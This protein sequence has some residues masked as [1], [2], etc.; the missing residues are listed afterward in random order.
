M[1]YM[2]RLLN[3]QVQCDP[4]RHWLLMLAL[5]LPACSQ[6]QFLAKPIPQQ[7]NQ[8]SIHTADPTQE[9]FKQYLAVQSPETQWPIAQW[10]LNALTLSAWYF[11]PTLKVAKS[12]YA[13]ALA[14]ITAAGLRP[15]IGLNGLIGKSNQANGDIRPFLY[16]L[17]FDIPIVTNGKREINIEIARHQADVAKIQLGEKAWQLRYQLSA[18]ILDRAE[19]MTTQSNLKQLQQAQFDLL[20]AF[21]KR[22]QTGMIGKAELLP[23]QLQYEQSKWQFA[24]NQI[25]LKQLEQKIVHDAGLTEQHLNTTSFASL[26]LSQLL[27]RVIESA[28]HGASAPLANALNIQ[29]V[30]M[31]NRMDIQRGLAQ[32]AQAEAKLKLEIAKLRPDISLS[33]GVAY[34]FGDQVWSLGIGGLLNLLNRSSDL[35]KQAEA[36]RQNEAD[37]FYALQHQIVQQ[38]EQQHLNFIQSY[39]LLEQLEQEAQQQPQRLNTIEQQ[40]KKGLI[41]KTEWLQS[42]VQ[43][44]HLNQRLISQ[45]ATVLRALLE[46]ENTMQMPL[47][48][49]ATSFTGNPQ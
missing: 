21:E 39:Q 42:Q 8:V 40:W 43:F 41:D 26:D 20:H 29:A 3:N 35:W 11:H 10:D 45:R 49:A 23:I 32:Y 36:V 14:G 13:V 33:P 19:L 44:Y 22:L 5:T 17:Q 34:E 1:P 16:N 25:Q 15:Q 7:E 9:G 6:V 47:L 24:Q 28:K 31:K 46:I 2:H 37:R 38:C 48:F 12:D 18:D 4:M 27:I 30:A